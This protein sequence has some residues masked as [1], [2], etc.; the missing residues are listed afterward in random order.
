MSW[1]L[2]RGG[3][4]WAAR[5]AKERQMK[6]EYR[7]AEDGGGTR[8]A[9][10]DATEKI[11]V[12]EGYAAVSSRRVAEK[13][14]LKSP[15]VHY[16]F[17]SM[18]DLFVAVYERSTREFF[19]RHLEAVTSQNPLRAIWE[20]STHP[21]RTRLA[22]EMIALANHRKSIRAITGR[23]LEQMHSI[24]VTFIARYLAEAG[25]DMQAY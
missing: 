7:I 22:Q 19:R 9:I 4:I 8:D 15:L 2:R 24:N 3:A 13:A 6:P 18:D 16:H 14:G 20:L 25:L 12:D 1:T 11:L 5:G 23:V 21:Q 17:G 10:L